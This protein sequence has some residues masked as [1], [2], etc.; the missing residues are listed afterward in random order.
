MATKAAVVY[1]NR[2]ETE[3]LH[4]EAIEE[5]YDFKDLLL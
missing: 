2:K 1:E 4:V 3:S 5:K